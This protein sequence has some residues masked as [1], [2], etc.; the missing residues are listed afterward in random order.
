MIIRKL[1][2]RSLNESVW[3]ELILSNTF[4]SCQIR[5]I[6][7]CP[8]STD[9]CKTRCGM[10]RS[11]QGCRWKD[12]LVKSEYS[13]WYVFLIRVLCY[14]SFQGTCEKNQFHNPGERVENGWGKH[15]HVRPAP[16]PCSRFYHR[17]VETFRTLPISPSVN[18][19]LNQSVP[20]I[21]KLHVPNSRWLKQETRHFGTQ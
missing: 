7:V 6:L 14:A 11:A 13:I 20:Q 16:T 9:I 4:C 18:Q 17:K 3:A 10:W 12:P 2:N 15:S 8:F 21:S 1:C 19:S 5:L